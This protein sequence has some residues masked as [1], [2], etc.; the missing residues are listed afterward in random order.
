M[1]DLVHL[2]T[3]AG[4]LGVFFVIFAESG[5]LIGFFLPG[6]SLIF[7]A[8]FLA[9][10]GIFNIW[11]LA[12]LLFFA[13]ALGD[14]LG[15]AFGRRV[16]F[17]IFNRE[18]SL[19]FDKE[20]LARAKVFFEKYGGKAVVFA[21]FVPVVRTFVPILAGVGEMR[22]RAFVLF[23]FLGA[24][25]WAVGI[26][27]LGFFLGK[28]VPNAEHYIVY[29]VGVIILVSVLPGLIELL[30]DRKRREKIIKALKKIIG[31]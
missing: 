22:Y 28:S 16:G 18:D 1:F 17:K 9:S 8:G 5:L 7:T 12:V 2:I 25:L 11:I 29:I 10:Q 3:T 27:L 31:L 15:Y 14:N 20:H 6:D 4:Y 30:R 21:R 13:A 19:L 24:L 23:N 26:V